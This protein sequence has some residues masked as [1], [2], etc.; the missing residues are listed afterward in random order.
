MEYLA[1]SSQ[2]TL[3]CAHCEQVF[4]NESFV[5]DLNYVGEE[6]IVWSNPGYQPVQPTLS[7]CLWHYLHRH[8]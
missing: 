2:L 7:A 4:V 3:E 5:A 1:I 8:T 6:P